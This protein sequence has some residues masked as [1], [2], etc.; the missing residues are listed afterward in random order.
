M[1]EAGEPLYY[2]IIGAFI[3]LLSFMIGTQFGSMS[4]KGQKNTD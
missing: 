1:I 4:K 2:Y 3:T